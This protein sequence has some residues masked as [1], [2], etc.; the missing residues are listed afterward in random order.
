MKSGPLE[1]RASLILRLADAADMAAWD[2]C[3]QIYRPLILRLALKEGLQ[4]A[5][6]DDLAQEVFS[7]VA[8]SVNAWLERQDRG[9]FRAWLLRIARNATVNMLTRRAQRRWGVGGELGAQQLAELP[10]QNSTSGEFELEYR[11]QVFQW[12]AAQVRETVAETTWSAFWLTHV[13][14]LSIEHAAQQLGLSH[15]KVYV[16]RSRIMARLR[17]LVSKYEVPA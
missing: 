15:G 13:E 6:A 16:A 1:T 2:D 5:D 3:V 14:G 11:R 17:E 9:G 8:A 7:S 10:C 12:A 4:P